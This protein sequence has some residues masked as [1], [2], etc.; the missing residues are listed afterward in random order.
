M[1]IEQL[2]IELDRHRKEGRRI[3]LLSGSLHPFRASHIELFEFARAQ[4][5]LLVVATQ[6]NARSCGRNEAS[7]DQTHIVAGVEAVDY[8]MLADEREADDLIRLIRPEVLVR[9]GKHSGKT[10]RAC[11]LINSYGGRLVMA[12]AG[13]GGN[14]LQ[15]H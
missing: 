7:A 9:I 5:D 10:S 11:K 14:L 2:L 12:Q 6:S 15:E 3:C 8:V 4:A 13:I 1:L